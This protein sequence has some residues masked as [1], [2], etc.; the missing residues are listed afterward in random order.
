MT[1]LSPHYA[2]E[3]FAVSTAHPELVRPVPAGYVPRLT[4]LVTTVLEPLRAAFGAP[5]RVLSGY[6]SPDLNR[7]VGGSLSSQHL[8]AEAADLVPVSGRSALALFAIL[9]ARA[10]A[11]VAL[12]HGQCIYYPDRNF[13][14]VALPSKR[15]PRATFCL[16]WP[17]RGYAY[18][19][20]SATADLGALLDGPA[21][22]TT[23]E[24]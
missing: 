1:P 20:I 17:A 23:P 9:R 19:V 14:H 13:M 12:P 6:R 8:F 10:A 3:E 22:A 21:V 7:A 15:F 18:Q 11:G 2:L 5:I 16:H 4:Q 24:G